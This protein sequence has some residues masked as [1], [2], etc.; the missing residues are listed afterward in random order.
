MG[1]TP[2]FHKRAVVHINGNTLDC[3][4]HN[5]R[6]ARKGERLPEGMYAV[7]EDGVTMHDL[8]V[9]NVYRDRNTSP[10]NAARW[11]EYCARA[12]EE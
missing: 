1:R 8:I 10:A 9:R 4:W 5:L 11:A 3:R 2:Q 6:P 12:Q 7:N